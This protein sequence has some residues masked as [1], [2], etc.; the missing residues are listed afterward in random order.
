V[1]EAL[2]RVLNAGFGFWVLG[3]GFW[4][5]RLSSL[6]KGVLALANL[7]RQ[8]NLLQPQIFN[9]FIEFM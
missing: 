9:Y 6:C 8:K 5:H 7:Y 3:F 2:G 4:W 1:A